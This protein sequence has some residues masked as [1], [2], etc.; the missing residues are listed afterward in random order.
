[1]RWA[2]FSFFDEDC[3]RCFIDLLSQEI[4]DLIIDL[5]HLFRRTPIFNFDFI[6]IFVLSLDQLGK[7]IILVTFEFFCVA[8]LLLIISVPRRKGIRVLPVLKHLLELPLHPALPGLVDC[9]L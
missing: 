6:P 9:V 2:N 8:Y 5:L 4:I 3:G 7:K 1:L